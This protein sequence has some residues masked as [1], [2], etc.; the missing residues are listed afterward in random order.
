[1]INKFDTKCQE[2]DHSRAISKDI[3]T[4]SI[5][6]SS[7]RGDS[8]DHDLLKLGLPEFEDL[9]YFLAC[10][11]RTLYSDLQLRF[12]SHF[13]TL[14][15]VLHKRGCSSYTHSDCTVRDIRNFLRAIWF[16]LLHPVIVRAIEAAINHRKY[17]ILKANPLVPS[18][19]ST[20][21]SPTEQGR[22]EQYKLGLNLDAPTLCT[23]F[24]H[25]DDVSVLSVPAILMKVS[26]RGLGI[27]YAS[28]E[29]QMPSGSSINGS[30]QWDMW[31]DIEEDDERYIREEIN[32]AEFQAHSHGHRHTQSQDDTGRHLRVE[33]TPARPRLEIPPLR[34]RRSMSV[35]PNQSPRVS[36]VLGEAN[37]TKSPTTAVKVG[38]R[39]PNITTHG[40]HNPPTTPDRKKSSWLH[41]STP[42]STR[43][44]YLSLPTTPSNYRMPFHG[45]AEFPNGP[46]PPPPKSPSQIA[47][48]KELKAQADIQQL[49]REN[50][51]L[52]EVLQQNQVLQR[53]N[54]QLQ[55]KLTQGT[56][57][58]GII[59]RLS[60][61]G[62]KARSRSRSPQ[63]F[64]RK[65]EADVFT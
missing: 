12:A 27:R 55:E 43:K 32:R 35:P 10:K 25:L 36:F 22:L 29:R 16:H 61:F 64:F 17:Q 40:P 39:L 57:S 50:S 8:S 51:R 26:Q 65:T 44:T 42:S 11:T 24:E 30:I 9:Y 34:H 37:D 15:E 58:R 46:P 62:S 23:L 45:E 52:Q 49:Q 19:Q 20:A 28:S 33:A 13:S 6:T 4:T 5:A 47:R 41:A 31:I 59:R 21:F 48:A 3:D 1:M 14:E 54:S 56:P 53:E 18:W 60:Q 2:L 38:I 7:S 63:K